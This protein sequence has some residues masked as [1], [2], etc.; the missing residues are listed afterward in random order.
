MW[1]V[2][3]DVGGTFT[4][5]FAWEEETGKRVTTKVLTTKS[6]RSEGV[7]QVIEAAQIGFEDISHLI[8]GTTAATNALLERSFPSPALITTE[9][10]RDTIEI[11]RQHRKH[12]YDPYQTK[13][14]PII[15]RRYRYTVPARLDDP[16]DVTPPPARA[17]PPQV[18]LGARTATPSLS[19]ER[20][21]ET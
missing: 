14:K 15:R 2:G 21:P 6:D 19:A 10:F 12:L 7:I 20:P 11:G 1:R 5:L 9:G 16:A 8:H 17:A 18:A 13:P 4:D 3:V